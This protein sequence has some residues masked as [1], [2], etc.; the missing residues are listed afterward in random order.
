MTIFR[1]NSAYQS[2]QAPIGKCFDFFVKMMIGQVSPSS[3]LSP[4]GE[5]FSFVGLIAPCCGMLH[6]QKKKSHATPEGKAVLL[7]TEG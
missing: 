4:E 1:N 2:W 7:K 3:G 5:A 6:R